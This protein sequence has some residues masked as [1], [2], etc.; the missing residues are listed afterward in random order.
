M[1]YQI[2]NQV[3]KNKK[4]KTISDSIVRKEIEKY[5]E[6]NK[7]KKIEEIT[8]DDIK[9]IRAKLHKAYSSFQTRKKNK[10]YLY[11][12]ELK[13]LLKIKKPQSRDINNIDNININNITDNLLS[14]T[15][16]TK[17]RLKDYTIIYKKI[18]EITGKPKSIADFGAGL[19]PLSY[20]LMNLKELNYYSYDID[21]EDIKFLN[22]YFDIMKKQKLNGKAAILDIRNLNETSEIPAVDIIFLFKVIDIINQ[23]EKDFKLSEEIIKELIKKAKFVVAS[24]ATK[25]ITG[26]TMNH[27]N[28][29]WFELMLQ[30]NNLNFK[31]IKTDNE[32]FYVISKI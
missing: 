14:I 6:S 12:E 26:K 2:I 17:E 27:P 8:R 3:K 4:Y 9:N 24:F 16:S 18:F 19:N 21:E 25:T 13:R 7:I 28:R 15:L 20:S 1:V 5:L 10:R 22:Q 32:I 29:K 11:L 31:I 23:S 30:R